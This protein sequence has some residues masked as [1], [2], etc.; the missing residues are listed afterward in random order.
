MQIIDY[1]SDTL[2]HPTDAM[3]RAAAEAEVGD[4]VF[5]EDPTVHRLQD[6]AAETTGKEAALFVPSG[7]MGN[8]V[9][10]LTHCQRGDEII[11]GR[12]SHIFINEVGGPSA[13]GGI[14]PHPVANRDDGTLDMQEVE[15]AIR[16]E[17]VHYPPTRLI[18][19][20][21]THNYCGGYP[22][23]AEYMQEVRA[24]ADRHG[25]KV[26]LDGARLFNAAV[27]LGV[28][29]SDL[30]RDADSVMFSL[31]K[32]LSAPVGSLICG[33]SDWIGRARKWRKM[34]GGGM[35]Q[36]GVIAAAGLEALVHHPERLNEDH[37]NAKKL[38]LG[39][40]ETPGI[41]IDCDRVHTN[42]L[43]FQLQH[44]DM[45]S[46]ALLN[47][48]DD[49]GVRILHMGAGWFRAVTHRHISGDMVAATLKIIREALK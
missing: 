3:R 9:S 42:I 27:A 24:L 36:A 5:D 29:A 30:T 14:H 34:V 31:S 37:E 49:R 13:L 7:T 22:L 18:C 35:R 41:R 28:K 44:P 47:Y 2:T 20:E 11:L 17:D 43:F 46:E 21:N 25:L 38:A 33:P 48:L 40:H 23:T 15:A 45:G 16:K 39:L 4:D 8:L 1:R 26:H 32:G 19:L 10:L 6:M 12:R